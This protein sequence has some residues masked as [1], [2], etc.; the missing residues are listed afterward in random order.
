MASLSS[1]S[2]WTGICIKYF[3]CYAKYSLTVNVLL[4]I[5]L[6]LNMRK[7]ANLLALKVSFFTLRQYYD[8]L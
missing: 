8:K 1:Y 3:A 2:K 6:V 5:L 4:T 7:Q